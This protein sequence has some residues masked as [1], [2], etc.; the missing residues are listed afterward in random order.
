MDQQEQTGKFGPFE[1]DEFQP[2]YRAVTSQS[3]RHGIRLEQ[4]YWRTLKRIAEEENCK[5]G[6]LVEE[7]TN[8]DTG[9]KNLTSALRV[10]CLNWTE[11]RLQALEALN[12]DQMIRN[13]IYA[14]PT[15]ALALSADKRLH[16]FNQPLLRLITDTF[17]IL[18]PEFI[19]ARLRLVM[20]VQI[21]TLIERLSENENRPIQV[22]IALGIDDRRMRGQLNVI[23][24]PSPSRN[25]ILGFLLP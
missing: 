1:K 21:E 4:S 16:S 8:L 11:E 6:E 2:V 17:S 25:V 10:S 18:D 22:G 5:L 7:L 23:M 19:P 20:D 9:N 12:S 3:G 15:S 14:C 24:A 13:I